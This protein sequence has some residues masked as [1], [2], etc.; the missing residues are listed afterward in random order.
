MISYQH[1]ESVPEK[2]SKRPLFINTLT[3]DYF[4]GYC[5]YKGQIYSQGQKWDDGCQYK[6]ECIDALRGR[7]KCDYR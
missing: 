6:C 4:T 7:Y 1:N 5:A 3:H 2:V